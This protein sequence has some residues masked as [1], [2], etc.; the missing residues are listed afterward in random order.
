MYYLLLTSSYQNLNE[1]YI[2][3]LINDVTSDDAENLTENEE[4]YYLLHKRYNIFKAKYQPGTCIAH[5]HKFDR[6]KGRFL[7]TNVFLLNVKHYAKYNE[8]VMT[9]SVIYL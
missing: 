1:Q 3:I 2:N 8:D 5:G 4:V 7:I 6:N 9:E